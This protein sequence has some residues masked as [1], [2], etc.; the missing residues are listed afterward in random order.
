[1][2]LELILTN[3]GLQPTERVRAIWGATVNG[4]PAQEPGDAVIVTL[5]VK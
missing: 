5:K 4:D 3:L 1:M 2:E